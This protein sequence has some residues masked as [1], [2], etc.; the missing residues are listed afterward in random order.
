MAS[1]HLVGG[2]TPSGRADRPNRLA[3]NVRRD[4]AGQAIPGKTQRPARGI[5]AHIASVRRKRGIDPHLVAG[6]SRPLSY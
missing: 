4:A 1:K 3:L 2:S 6:F 5:G